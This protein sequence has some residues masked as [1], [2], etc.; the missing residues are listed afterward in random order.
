MTKR[1]KFN[2]EHLEF[3]KANVVGRSERELTEIFNQRFNT[4]LSF[5][6]VRFFKNRHK[7]SNGI[8]GKFKKGH[9][10][11]NTG[12]K[13][14]DEVKEKLKQNLFKKGNTPKN[15]VPIGTERISKRDYVQ[16]KVTNGKNVN[17][18]VTK[19]QY[20]YEQH[21]GP[22][23][24][25]YVVIFADGDRRNFDIDNLVMV[26]Q[27]ELFYLNKHHLI[28]NDCELTKTGLLIAKVSIAAKDR[29]K[30]R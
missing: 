5:N 23:P 24:K 1:F 10:P 18:W 3:V 11:A 28:Y 2:D 20:I 30:N 6:Q 21:H 15:S 29:S 22:V 8:N 7:L 27:K 13:T 19:H 14:P 16:V 9:I 26:S 12:K 4:S 25:G 17:N